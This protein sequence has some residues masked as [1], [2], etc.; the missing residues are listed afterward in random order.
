MN[1]ADPKKPISRTQH[2]CRLEK[3]G[4]HISFLLTDL[5]GGG[6]EL[7]LTPSDAVTREVQLFRVREDA[8]ANAQRQVKN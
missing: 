7:K 4:R 5:D 1:G 3:D 6:F 8:M 2:I